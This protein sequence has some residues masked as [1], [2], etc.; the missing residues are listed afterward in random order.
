MARTAV[1]AAGIAALIAWSWVRLEQPRLG[2]GEL[3][4]V[5][6]LAV[7]PALVRERRLRIAAVIGASVGAA[8]IALGVSPFIRPFNGEDDYLSPLLDGVRDGF[9]DFYDVTVPFEGFAH[10]DM[11][12][13]LLV[14]VFVFSLVA[15]LAVAARKPVGAALVLLI[16]AGWPATILGGGDELLRGALLLAAVLALLGGLGTGPRRLQTQV[17]VGGAV[18]VIALTLSASSA[19]AR[20]Q[21]VSWETWDFYNEPDEAVGVAYV[22]RANY[23]GIRFPNKRTRVLRVRAPG[24]AG[25]WRATTLDAFTGHVWDEDLYSIE[26]VPTGERNIV[27]EGE[28]LPEAAFDP[29]NWTRA[30]FTVEALADD[31][32]V[33]I[34][35]PV[36]YAAG[37]LAPIQYASG[38]VARVAGLLER[39]DEYTVWAYAPRPKPSALARS[40]ADYPTEIADE[41]R[42]LSVE[43]LT[44]PT[45]G[46]QRGVEQMRDLFANHRGFRPYAAVYE[47]A[48]AIAGGAS[49]PYAATVALEAWFRTGGNFEYDET[50]PRRPPSEPPLAFFVTQSKAGY[51]QHFAG[52]MALMLRYLGI[53][54]R[55][56]AGFTSGNYDRDRRVWNVTDRNAHTWVEV[57][58]RGFGW[59]PFD[60]TPGRGNLGG[61]YSASSFSFDAPGAQTVLRGSGLDADTLLR[62]QLNRNSQTEDLTPRDVLRAAEEG[63][64]GTRF[65]FT[66]VVLLVLIALALLLAGGKLARRRSRYLTKDPRR[67]AS[68][69]RRELVEFLADQRI[70]VPQ[71]ATLTE[72][73]ALVQA[74]TGVETRRFVENIGLARF[75]PLA[76]AP[77]AARNAR[78][79][80]RV[81]KRKLR[82]ALS[83]GHRIRGTFS[84]RSL[85]LR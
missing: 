63:E 9:L 83:A 11:H 54:A 1:F 41:G 42:Y 14:A 37:R 12:G 79:E 80:L 21:F 62:A 58:F 78:A 69:Y 76:V 70:G 60:P 61:P 71:S 75:G 35:E 18:A 22:W 40:P 52:A 10:P 3:V 44:L 67:L 39:G 45:F 6:A 65:G 81:V 74:E 7:V 25:Y 4:A 51:C 24:R 27:L 46:A 16:G 85:A 68:A 8:W 33:G 36:A 72:L 31:H 17:L 29:G 49:N 82:K 23:D 32:L 43:G 30:N 84:L 64:E 59:L 20:G 53:P 19:V 34:A 26:S 57:W 47:Q 2:L 28:F 56:A 66:Q 50:P 55:V 13:V 73:R 15:G 48:R 5:A 38:G 77:R